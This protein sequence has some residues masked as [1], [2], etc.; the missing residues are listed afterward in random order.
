VI[1]KRVL[2]GESSPVVPFILK[3]PFP[4]VN[5]YSSKVSLVL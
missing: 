3:P 1:S 4:M 2:V 5:P